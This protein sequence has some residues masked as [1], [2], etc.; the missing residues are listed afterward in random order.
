MSFIHTLFSGLDI[1]QVRFCDSVGW[2]SNILYSS[3]IQ[4]SVIAVSTTMELNWS[5]ETFSVPHLIENIEF[6]Q[7]LKLA[8][9][10]ISTPTSTGGDSQLNVNV[11]RGK[12]LAK[13][14]DI[15][16]LHGMRTFKKVIATGA[17]STTSCEQVANEY[18]FLSPPGSTSIYKQFKLPV[19]Y[20]MPL[21]ILPFRAEKHVYVT[22][23][24]LVK[25]RPRPTAVVVNNSISI[26]EKHCVIKEGDVLAITSVDKRCTS[27][28]VV[29]FLICKHNDKTIGLPMSCVGNFT[30]LTD[31]TLFT[32]NDLVSKHI[33]IG[34]P[35][36]VTFHTMTS[37]NT[38]PE[39]C[40]KTLHRGGEH[41]IIPEEQYVV[42]NIIKEQ[43]LICTKCEEK[44]DSLGDNKV[45][46][47]PTNCAAVRSMKVRLPLFHDLKSYQQ[48]LNARYCTNL[49]MREVADGTPIET[50]GEPSVTVRK[51][52][53]VYDLGSPLLPPRKELYPPS[54]T[55]W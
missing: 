50:V 1:L 52:S 12:A 21:R 44:L 29:D 53:E 37:D 4:S 16:K 9:D 45:Y 18:G 3:S 19:N 6:P 55:G 51:L 20:S 46:Y 30:V 10:L 17:G 32:L 2:H 49:R 24:D 8:N 7:L 47:I 31:E 54:E 36:K 35:Q 23:G 11:P 43:Y 39:H 13:E 14:G 28:G 41:H 5:E 38:Q 33:D 48:S 25:E 22:A 27:S 40:S 26:P 42:E 15:L 34:L